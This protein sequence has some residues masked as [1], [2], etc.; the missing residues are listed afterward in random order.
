L[1]SIYL[2]NF[3]LRVNNLFNYLIKMEENKGKNK[4]F[5]YKF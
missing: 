2:L 1:L 4:F 5:N 3:H